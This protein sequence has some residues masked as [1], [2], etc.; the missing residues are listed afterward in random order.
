MKFREFL[1]NNI[2]ILDG[3][4]GTLLQKR[5]LIAGEHPERWNITHPEIITE[6]HK[7]YFDSG[8]N[9]VNANTF[10]ANIFNFAEDELEKIIEKAFE[11]VKK[12]RDTSCS[13]QEKFIALDIGPSGRLLSPLGD[14]DFEDAVSAFRKTVSCGVKYGADLIVIE[15]MNDS[16]ETKAALLA[17][18][19][20]CDLPVIVTN[21]Y[22]ED[23]KLMTGAT[24]EAMAAL[25]E[26]MG[27]DAVGANCSLGPKGLFEVIRRLLRVSSI[28]VV[29]KPNAGLPRDVGGETVF[30]VK[31]EEFAS[32][33]ALLMKEG[34]RAVGGCC[35]TTRSYGRRAA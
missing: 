20:E 1:K 26:G 19:E 15:T 22:S 9:V 7:A 11:N 14:L 32:D 21:A 3:G 25:V 29:F 27:A 28:P 23:G 33:V 17:V 12:A 6:L 18:K 4:M 31:E 35:G 34:V 16:F 30:D 10:G 24:P 5:G 2:V 8:S 13:P